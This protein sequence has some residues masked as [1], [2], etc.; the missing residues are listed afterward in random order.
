MFHRRRTKVCAGDV[1]TKPTAI[2]SYR[3]YHVDIPNMTDE[4]R[5]RIE[6]E[7][8]SADPIRRAAFLAELDF[9]LVSNLLFA[10]N[11]VDLVSSSVALRADWST[12]VNS[13]HL[14]AAV[15]A[16]PPTG[17]GSVVALGRLNTGLNTISGLIDM[18]GLIPPT[19]VKAIPVEYQTRGTD[20]VVFSI[21]SST[22]EISTA[23]A[24]LVRVPVEAANLVASLDGVMTVRRLVQELAN[25]NLTDGDFFLA[26][27]VE[28]DV[29]NKEE[30]VSWWG[31]EPLQA[32]ILLGAPASIS[33]QALQRWLGPRADAMGGM[34][35]RSEPAIPLDKSRWE[36]DDA[37]VIMVLVGDRRG[38]I[39]FD[40]E[41]LDVVVAQQP[42]FRRREF[43]VLDAAMIETH[44][45]PDAMRSLAA[46]FGVDVDKIDWK[47]P[48]SE[49]SRT[50]L[51]V[52][53]ETGNYKDMVM[54][55]HRRFHL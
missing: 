53:H 42:D 33:N 3:W 37:D 12:A 2:R 18:A 44:Q 4:T 25:F 35:G 36:L 40:R 54:E 31:T 5:I 15:V 46:D 27:Y 32:P 22:V 8:S 52:A 17:D 6:S 39:V 55:I 7:L 45:T 50:V 20:G 23:T 16:D 24:Q 11:D 49:L 51:R 19:V 14:V 41:V 43:Q 48:I 26:D 34:L 1:I 21:G 38:G 30:V 10:E 9:S 28:N 13:D 29:A 47:R